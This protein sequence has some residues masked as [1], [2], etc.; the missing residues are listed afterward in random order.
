MERRFAFERTATTAKMNVTLSRDC[1]LDVNNLEHLKLM[2]CLQSDCHHHSVTSPVSLNWTHSWF[3]WQHQLV[4]WFSGHPHTIH[5]HTACVV[6]CHMLKM[7][8]NSVKGSL[9][10]PFGEVHPPN[11]F[12]VLWLGSWTSAVWHSGQIFILSDHRFGS[13]MISEAS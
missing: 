4:P 1:L 13:N 11:Y 7:A 10:S 8:V 5:T 3:V 6:K 9:L 12:F 2:Y